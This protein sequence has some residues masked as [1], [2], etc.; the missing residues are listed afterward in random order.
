MIDIRPA[1]IDDV[2]PI[3]TLWAEA[4]T[5]PTV[6]DDEEALLALLTF[7][8]ASLLIAVDGDEIVG[9]LIVG[10]DGWRGSF[11]R[12]AVSAEYRRRGI[13]SSLVSDGEGRLK[14]Y[15]A[16]RIAPFAIADEQA[17][18]AFWEAMGYVAQTNRQRLVKN[19]TKD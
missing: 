11:Y 10:W 6:T 18:I 13:A 7:S 17:A 8:P 14:T 5:E 3:L 19:L 1:D 4:D 15:G 9:S 2:G 12:L 16:R